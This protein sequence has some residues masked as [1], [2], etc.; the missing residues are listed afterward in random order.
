MK[1][2]KQNDGPLVLLVC[3]KDFANVAYTY[4]EALKS[5]GVNAIAYHMKGYELS[6]LNLEHAASVFTG[7]E[8]E[9][10]NIQKAKVII[11]MHSQIGRSDLF[12]EFVIHGEDRRKKRLIVFHG[13]TLYRRRS[14]TLNMKF[15]RMG[16]KIILIQTLDLW[17]FAPKVGRVWMLPAV[18]TDALKPTFQPMKRVKSVAH[19]PHHAVFKGS[20][21]INR[22]MDR[23]IRDTEICNLFNYT[24]DDKT[25]TYKANIERINNCDIYIESLS[26]AE[27]V[28]AHDWSVT[29][30]EAAAL[31]KIVVTNVMNIKRY[32]REY[33]PCALQVANTE[34]QLYD[35]L[36]GL[37]TMKSNIE[38]QRMKSASRDW[39]E[40]LHSYKAI[41]ERLKRVIGV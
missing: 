4:Q 9:M 5:V 20:R 18:D 8:E 30:L 35:V 41:G 1:Q 27:A 36:K 13:G 39:V 3:V 24:Y 11:Y 26:Q 16:A 25:T 10:D 28:N 37:V 40:Q 17:K 7:T 32:E 6:S 22:V 34:E 12:R 38:F 14:D 2:M 33:G 31:G 21:T 23:L 19:H 15:K 29:A